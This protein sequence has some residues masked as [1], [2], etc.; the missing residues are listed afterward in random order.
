MMRRRRRSQAK[1][2]NGAPAQ[3]Q[4]PA[5]AKPISA[6]DI[7]NAER[8]LFDELAAHPDISPD[9]P[10]GQVIQLKN[11]PDRGLETQPDLSAAERRLFGD[12]SVESA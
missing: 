3:T 11:E 5:A 9:Q 7:S 2:A 10:T 4:R 12:A 8:A 1:P 6:Q